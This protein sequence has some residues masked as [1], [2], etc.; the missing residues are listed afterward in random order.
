MGLLGAVITFAR[1]PLYPPHFA[2]TDP[3]G[4]SALADQQLAGLI[5]WVP[6]TIPYLAAA[7]LLIGRGLARGAPD[8]GRA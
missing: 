5:M 3:F 7:L 8:V 4:L 6:A 1:V 2:T